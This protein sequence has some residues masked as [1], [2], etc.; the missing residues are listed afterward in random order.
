MKMRWFVLLTIVA[1]LI[2]TF[3]GCG[4]SSGNS[5]GSNN[6]ASYFGT[7]SP[8]DAWSWTIT[9]DATG[10]GTFSAKDSTNGNTYSGNVATLSNKF[11]RLTITASNDSNVVVGS[12]SATAYA[13][14]FPNTAVIVKPAG[15]NDAPVIG[16]A[17][18]ACP[19]PAT[20]NW[21]KV[22]NLYWDV[23]T[24]PAFGTAVTS[25]NIG[26]LTFSVTPSLLGGTALTPV[27]YSGSCSNGVISSTANTT[28]GVTPSGVFIGDQGTNGGVI[29]M[30]QPSAKIGNTAI[31]Q[32]G[33][34]F[35]GFV[36][37]THPPN[38]A[39]GLPVDKTQA[40]WSRTKGDNLITAGEYTNFANG[41][42]DSC[43]GGDSCATL[44]LDNE[45]AP[46]EFTGTMIDSHAGSHPFTLMINQI[47]GK[48]MI[49]GFSREQAG[50]DPSALYPYLFVVMEQ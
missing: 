6:A 34:E 50:S 2:V 18:G 14:E 33:R 11:L 31:L 22:P 20:Y 17:Q 28:F 8:G 1:A 47:N 16:A 43:P 29:G 21:I 38:G 23:T 12:S 39:N 13:I 26:S 36:F 46:G 24:D 9:K 4:N 27:T 25:G 41:T 15:Y 40:I 42:E 7:Q 48:Y 10:S 5:T 45:V 44:S 30:L 37:M 32:A 35:R 3:S 49:F 19:S